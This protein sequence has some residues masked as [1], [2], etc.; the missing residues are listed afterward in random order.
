MDNF[1]LATKWD[2]QRLTWRV[3]KFPSNDLSDEL[4]ISTMERA[5]SVWAKYADLTFIEVSSECR[6]LVSSPDSSYLD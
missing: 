3:T 4:V 1:N 6:L 5:F 2:K